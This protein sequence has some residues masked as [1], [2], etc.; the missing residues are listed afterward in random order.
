[1]FIDSLER[2]SLLSAALAEGVL[3]VTGTAGNDMIHVGLNRAGTIVVSEA[4]QPARPTTRGERPERPTPT[5]TKFT[6]ADVTSIV[7]NA[8]AGNDLV[9]V[10][11][12]AKRGA[13]QL[14]ATINGDAGNDRLT[15]GP[16]NDTING[17]DG[18]DYLF[19]GGGGID[20]L[21]GGAN[22]A[23]SR[24]NRGDVA[25]ADASD[26]V[27]N[28]EVTRAPRTGPVGTRTRSR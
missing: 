7:I 12:T 26:I 8:G 21:D 3:T 2:R 4:V 14:G 10:G 27:S 11:R 17:G 18:N 23:V 25:V 15:G 5:I 20:K 9:S 16:G 6:A 22:D 1:M 28:V 13:T 24:R 19:A